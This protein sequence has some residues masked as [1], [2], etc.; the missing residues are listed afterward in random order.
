[1]RRSLALKT[2]IRSPL[3]TLLTFFLIA[4]ASFALFSRVTDYAV[5]M[6]ET[7]NAESLY[8][9]VAALDNTLPETFYMLDDSTGVGFVPDPKPWPKDGKM[10]E[11][12]SLP[13]VT[14]ADERYM[15]AGMV[16]DYQRVV[17][18]GYR[19]FRLG[20]FAIEGSYL[21]YEEQDSP[22][23]LSLKFDD[24]KVLAGDIVIDSGLPLEITTMTME[25][26]DE[27]KEYFPECMPQSFYDGMKEGSRYLVLGSYDEADRR[28]LEIPTN[29]EVKI[30]NLDG[31][32]QDYLETEEFAQ[33]KKLIEAYRQDLYTYDIVYTADMRSI[34]CMNEHSMVIAQGRPLVEGDTD[35]CVVNELFLETNGLS[36][37]DKV[38]VKLGDKLME[39]DSLW[40]ARTIGYEKRFSDFVSEAELEIVGAYRFV[41]DVDTRTS[42]S[43][44]SYSPSTVFVPDELL[45]VKDLSDYEHVA[46]EISVYVEDA[47]DIEAFREAAE[48]LAAQMGFGLRFSDGG[49]ASVKNSFETG[50][51]TAF[52]TTALYGLGAALAL[53]LAVYLYV[54]RNRQSYAIMR[55]LGVPGKKAGEAVVLPL[56]ILSAF[57]VPIGGMVGLFYTSGTAAKALA[58][59]SAIAPEG[60]VPN[61]KL[62]LGV[63]VLIL[64]FELVFI[65]LTTMLFLAGMRKVQPLELLQEGTARK[66]DGSRE[67]APAGAA[68]AMEEL[69][70]GKLCAVGEIAA[71]GRGKYGAFRHVGSY[72]LR[73]M[74]R[75]TAKTAVS[76]VMVAV[77]SCG[78]GAL[79]LARLSFQD[80]FREMD[81][82]G[83][84][85]AFSSSAVNELSDSGLT[86]DFY[87][88]GKMDVCTN[89]VD[90]SRGMTL[91]DDIDRYLQE[92]YTVRY[93]EGFDSSALEGE[94]AVCLMG[95]TLAEELDIAP[96][97][98]VALITKNLY[99]FMG[100][101]YEE[102][103]A[104]QS[105]AL[106][107]SKEY[108]VIGILESRDEEISTGIFTAANNAAEELY[109]QPFPVGYCEFKLTDNERLADLTRLLDEQKKQGMEYAPRAYAYVDSSGLENIRRI[110]DLLVLLFPIAV[111]A[112]VLMEVLA[113]GLVVVQ[114]A[115]EAAFLRVLGVTKRRT[116]CM[117]VLEQ[118][119][120][121]LIGIILVASG[122][123]LYSPGV[124]AR[125][126]G[127]LAFCYTLYFLGCVCGAAAAAVQITRH[128][129]MELL[130]VKE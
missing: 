55:T 89:G 70:I 27:Q 10:E 116:R 7:S 125:S 82:R 106:K 36:V 123:A 45:P 94:E 59:M 14:L 122:L 119:A 118:V 24:V 110:R 95:K 31:L 96:G 88:Y 26:T 64:V 85:T 111:A 18:D 80:T 105:A 77:L 93:A 13:G 16:G 19:G 32:G 42:E 39:Q 102:K 51:R 28:R 62:P 129:I 101:L 71:P 112:A 63:A 2:M 41:D 11:F 126:V 46:G 107:A 12:F 57:A 20:E 8:H 79:A 37:G 3:K 100:D 114:S 68:P 130:Q 87:Y 78:I 34:P 72:V 103:E 81:V 86:E 58:D 23:F 35:A 47:H 117:L 33:Q 92:D 84:A 60:Y 108:K 127:T 6:R 73:H 76:L 30:F 56:A 54:G 120:L 25:E 9:G 43:D 74:R 44:W 5:T 128:R 91:T 38:N 17:D 124:F 66:H 52:L 29:D 40:G 90:I 50:R 97:G 53:L 104:L 69:D 1:M 48:P 99:T 21:G 109:G 121:C 75:G 65:S 83:S 98:K 115:K 4:A 22:G 67:M 15:T 49:W 61:A 113:A